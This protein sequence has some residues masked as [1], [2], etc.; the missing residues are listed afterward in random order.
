MSELRRLLTLLL[1]LMLGI[2]PAAALDWIEQASRPGPDLPPRGQS[3]FDELFRLDGGGY[4][5]PYPFDRLVAELEA[6]VDNG[7]QPGVRRVFVPMGRSLQRD[8][9]APDYF[10]Q[11]REVIALEGEPVN[12]GGHAG[13]VL[14]YRLFIAHQ[15]ASGSLEVI[16]YN[17][18]AG[19]FEFQ[20]V[21]NYAAGQNPRVHTA[22]RVMCMS[23]HH[24]AG[25]IFP[26]RPWRETSFDVA[27]ARR[28]AAALPQRFDS[29]IDVIG[30]D[31]GVIDLLAERAN[32]LAAAQAVWRDGCGSR[33]CRVAMLRAVLQFR[34]SGNSS[35]DWNSAAFRRHYHDELTANWAQRW[36]DGLALAGSRLSDRDPFAADAAAARHDPLRPRPAQAVWREVDPVLSRGIIFRLAGFFT[37]ADIERLDR[38]LIAAAGQ[39]QPPT[40]SYTAACSAR[41]GSDG[42]DLLSCGE[43]NRVDRL[44]ASLQIRLDAGAVGGLEISSLRIPGD[45]NLLQPQASGLVQQQGHLRAEL[46]QRSGLSSR[47]ANGDRLESLTLIRSDR[48]GKAFVLFK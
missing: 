19:R 45:V 42:H 14:E 43:E 20:V 34:L 37:A 47:L 9:P 10:D 24:N 23:C 36:P 12:P 41:R 40:R 31:A 26:R 16:S 8:T 7:D 32:Y 5:I 6:K 21:D 33:E 48:H 39:R 4:R 13:A 30:L 27:I 25:P 3:R 44:Q 1:I 17:D 18:A 46:R 29:A 22:A 35:F 28:L 38:S 11:P 2:A 15:P